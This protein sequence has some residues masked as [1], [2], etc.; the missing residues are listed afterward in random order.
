MLPKISAFSTA[1]PAALALALVSAFPA[2]AQ[3][4]PA[5]SAP[6]AA[7][8]QANVV[9]VKE[10][11]TVE[12][13]AQRL[14]GSADAADE[15]RSFNQIA[16]GAQ[17]DVG[18]PLVLPGPERDA[19]I[20][21]LLKADQAFQ[22]AGKAD[23]GT[24]A[25][26]LFKRAVSLHDSA[27]TARKAANYAR[28]QTLA[29]IAAAEFAKAIEEAGLRANVGLSLRVGARH[30][31]VQV[32][33]DGVADEKLRK[34]KAAATTGTRVVTG[35]G[36][37][38]AI[39]LPAG[40]TLALGE[41]TVV[42]FARATEDKRDKTTRVIARILQGEVEV[43]SQAGSDAA[44]EFTLNN[45]GIDISSGKARFWTSRNAEGVFRLSCLENKVLLN[46]DS[47]PVELA[48]N[49]GAF[50]GP[51]QGVRLP[52]R[53]P[54]APNF[55]SPEKPELTTARQKVSLK[56]ELGEYAGPVAFLLREASSVEA[57]AKASPV[58]LGEPAHTSDVLTPGDHFFLVRAV[59]ANGL[60][61]PASAVVK[62]TVVPNY[63]VTLGKD[64]VRATRGGRN[65]V[66]PGVVFKAAAG[67]ADSTVA[68]FEYSVNGGPFQ[69]SD[70]GVELGE[71]GEY[72]LAARGV[73]LDGKQG[74]AVQEIVIVDAKAPDLRVHVGEV[75]DFPGYGLVRSISALVDD[76]TK[77]GKVEIS[78]NKG[79]FE[80]Y[81]NPLKLSIEKDFRIAFRAHDVFGNRAETVFTLEHLTNAPSGVEASPAESA[82][83]KKGFK[84]F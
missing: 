49:F 76:D 79:P 32:I 52:I 72:V 68:A 80:A 29:G 70:K 38:A 31:E 8:A 3:N 24:H 36:A 19:A 47:Q 56:W 13:L 6:Q 57:L 30:G 83:K 34:D 21:A 23:A 71:T 5:E 65:V 55:T 51:G 11:D 58:A 48:A 67:K 44:P 78:L 84:L 60:K 4:A 37:S 9:F 15:L 74:E 35:P 33:Q 50:A 53:L 77:L 46:R 73:G 63:E 64:V 54:P 1:M 14:L 18:A 16:A 26:A 7:E 61:G 17:P 27:N 62:V 75:V 25:A 22:A 69:R 20:A 59:D 39:E 43:L 2:F 42:E 81:T 40:G 66:G 10:G 82:P 28:A 12:S 45:G 41:S